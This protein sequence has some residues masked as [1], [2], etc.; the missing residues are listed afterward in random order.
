MGFKQLNSFAKEDLIRIAKEQREDIAKLEELIEG[1][2]KGILTAAKSLYDTGMQISEISD[3][4]KINKDK[5]EKY[6]QTS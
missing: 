1:E 2:E 4:L 5:V 3:R 6:L